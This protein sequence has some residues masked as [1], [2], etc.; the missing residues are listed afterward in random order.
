MDLKCQIG[1]RNQEKNMMW[2]K[3]ICA[4]VSEEYWITEFEQQFILAYRKADKNIQAVVD[5]MLGV[6]EDEDFSA[7]F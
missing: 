1:T 2:K 4:I 5:R 6:E 3:K 7:N